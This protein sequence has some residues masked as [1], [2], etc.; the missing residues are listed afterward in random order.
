MAQAWGFD[1]IIASSLFSIGI[2]VFYFYTVNHTDETEETY[3]RLLYDGNNI[4][5]TLLSEG[6]PADWSA[7]NVVKIGLTNDKRINATKLKYFYTLATNDYEKTKTLFNTNYNY[8]INMSQPMII[9]NVE[10]GYIGEKDVN[11]DNLVKITR[12]T[13]YNNKITTLFIYMW[14]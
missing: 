7:G 2:I 13:I 11:P 9:D 1:L 3:S 8:Y 4:A 6:Y 10:V 14:N 12:V 5:E